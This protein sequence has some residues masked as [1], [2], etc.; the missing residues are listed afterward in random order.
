MGDRQF[1]RFHYDPAINTTKQEVYNFASNYVALI[2][3]RAAMASKPELTQA[4]LNSQKTVTLSVLNWVLENCFEDRKL[5]ACDRT[6]NYQRNPQFRYVY[7]TFNLDYTKP[8]V[9][10]CEAKEMRPITSSNVVLVDGANFVEGVRRTAGFDAKKAPEQSDEDYCIEFLSSMQDKTFIIVNNANRT[11]RD[12]GLIWVTNNVIEFN[13]NIEPDI[14]PR[15]YD[16]Y[17]LIGLQYILIKECRFKE[18]SVLILSE[19]NYSWYLPPSP[20][21]EQ[22]YLLLHKFGL[23][24]KS[25]ATSVSPKAVN[26]RFSRDGTPYF[27]RKDLRQINQQVQYYSG[28]NL[29]VSPK[30]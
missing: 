20:A 25:I 30:K 29:P 16:D 4:L 5:F 3:D 10:L 1:S 6:S 22:N 9:E 19:D 27:S 13:L 28:S 7:N 26:M 24:S 11:R 12:F 21:N 23:Q 14:I 2:N 18:G 15:E 17:I 8:L